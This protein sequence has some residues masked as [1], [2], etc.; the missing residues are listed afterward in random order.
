MVRALKGIGE[1]S[2]TATLAVF[3][4]LVALG[5][6]PEGYSYLSGHLRP[7]GRIIL[8]DAAVTVEGV[9]ITGRLEKW[10]ECDFVSA[11]YTLRY[12]GREVT[13]P[14]DRIEIIGGSVENYP[15]GT[16]A[17][18]GPILLK[19]SPA[20]SARLERLRITGFHECVGGPLA[21]LGF[22]TET[23]LFDGDPFAP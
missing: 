4:A 8:T 19:L 10:R 20:Q 7:V 21:A 13:L 23:A 12:G 16:F 3:A 1:I 15:A 11:S 22:V 9:E 14:R 5:I 17:T 6:A 18:F 2:W